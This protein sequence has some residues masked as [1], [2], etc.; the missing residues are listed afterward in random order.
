MSST[1]R[2]SPNTGVGIRDG[3]DLSRDELLFCGIWREQQSG[4]WGEFNAQALAKHTGVGI[5]DGGGSLSDE[6]LFCGIWPERR[7]VERPTL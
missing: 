1:R 5:R 6:L 4:E 2:P 3:W 7:I